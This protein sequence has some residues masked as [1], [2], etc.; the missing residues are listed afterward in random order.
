MYETLWVEMVTRVNTCFPVIEPSVVCNPFKD[1]T[2]VTSRLSVRNIFHE[3]IHRSVGIGTDPR[4]DS[5][6][7]GI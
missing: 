1:G 3:E 6:W 4:F 5:V 7:T 2:R